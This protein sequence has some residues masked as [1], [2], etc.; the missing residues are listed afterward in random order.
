L[1]ELARNL[2]RERDWDQFHSPRSLL[3]ALVGE[4]G[5]LAAEFQWIQDA[6]LETGLTDSRT[7]ARVQNELGDVLYCV[8][9]LADVLDIDLE[10]AF[11][12]KLEQI[13]AQYP[14][15]LSRGSREKW[16]RLGGGPEADGKKLS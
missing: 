10:R 3:L 8:L 13:Q 16:S 6:E 4:V 9:R 14:V 15:E 12:E 11:R 7:E 1:Q 2:A 5:E